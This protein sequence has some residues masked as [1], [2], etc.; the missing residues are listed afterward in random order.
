MPANASGETTSNGAT[1]TSPDVSP[2]STSEWVPIEN[3]AGTAT[4]A[5]TAPSASAVTR[6]M[7]VGVEYNLT[8]TDSPGANPRAV[9][10]RLSP[11]TSCCRE[12]SPE[13][14]GEVVRSAADAAGGVGATAPPSSDVPARSRRHPASPRP[15]LPPRLQGPAAR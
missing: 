14:P 1:N 3:P 15:R 9:T 6:P 4:V 8:C 13:T 7:N 2:T 10:V 5:V 12:S 11:A